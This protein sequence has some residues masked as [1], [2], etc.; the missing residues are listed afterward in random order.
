MKLEDYQEISINLS[1]SM[2]FF[3]DLETILLNDAGKQTETGILTRLVQCYIAFVA[4]RLKQEFEN[5]LKDG[6]GGWSL[7]E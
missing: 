3:E 4:F 1:E 7:T 2:H 6:A 5:R